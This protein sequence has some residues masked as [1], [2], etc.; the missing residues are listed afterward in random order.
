[1]HRDLLPA[2]RHGAW[3]QIAIA[4]AILPLAAWSTRLRLFASHEPDLLVGIIAGVSNGI[5]ATCMTIGLL[6]VFQ[7]RFDRRPSAIGQYI[8]HASYWIY[9]IHLPLLVFVAGAL[10]ATS[11][12]AA[13]KYL[14]TVFVVVPIVFASYHFCVRATRLGGFLKGRK[15]DQAVEQTALP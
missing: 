3:R 12:P 6:G 4:I 10:S 7:G 14:T 9:L 15:N 8:S 11:L 1:L 2:F 13:A 5:I